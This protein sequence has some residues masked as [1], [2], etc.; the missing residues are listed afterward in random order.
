MTVNRLTV[1]FIIALVAT[2][3]LSWHTFKQYQVA[4]CV[5]GGGHWDKTAKKCR[6]R[7][8]YLNRGIYRS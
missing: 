5:D 3:L 8:I 6:D 1:A 2:G 4:A 7:P